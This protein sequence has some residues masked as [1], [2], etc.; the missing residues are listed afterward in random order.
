MSMTDP[1][2]DFIARIRNGIR[3]DGFVFPSD[4]STLTFKELHRH[5]LLV[6]PA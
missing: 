4:R 6:N 2:A 3:E 1:I 5:L